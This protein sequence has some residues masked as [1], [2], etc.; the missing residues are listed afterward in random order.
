MCSWSNENILEFDQ[1]EVPIVYQLSIFNGVVIAPLPF[2]DVVA[3]SLFIITKL[4]LDK[5]ATI[6][7]PIK[8]LFSILQHDLC[9]KLT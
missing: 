2:G 7:V 5:M 3:Y 9:Y 4:A 6:A 8:L 1:L